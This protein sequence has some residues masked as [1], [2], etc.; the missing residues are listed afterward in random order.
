MIKSHD[1]RTGVYV[2]AIVTISLTTP[3]SVFA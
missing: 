2:A 1:L 3:L